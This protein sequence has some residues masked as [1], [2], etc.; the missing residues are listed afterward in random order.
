MAYSYET[1]K[2]NQLSTW[3]YVIFAL[4]LIVSAGIGVFYAIRDRHRKSLQEFLLAGRNMSVAPVALSLVAS[5]MSAITLLGSPA[6]M[7]NYSTMFWWIG[8]SYVF[9]AYGAAHIYIPIF[10]NLKVTSLY[11]VSAILYYSYLLI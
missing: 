1:G 6:E 4:I 5:F 10:Y 9:V 11:E 8:L 3:D 7:Y 2:T